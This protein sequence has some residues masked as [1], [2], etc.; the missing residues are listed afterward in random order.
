M[1]NILYKLSYK[2]IWLLKKKKVCTINVN[3]FIFKFVVILNNAD[4]LSANGNC[5]VC[6]ITDVVNLNYSCDLVVE[7]KGMGVRS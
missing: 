4:E 7:K 5:I 1:F 6:G 3:I 2:L